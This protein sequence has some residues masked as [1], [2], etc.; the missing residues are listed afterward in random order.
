VYQRVKFAHTA[1]ALNAVPSENFTPLRSLNV[2]AR[3]FLLV[4]HAV[5]SDGTTMLVPFLKVTRLSKI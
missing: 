5:A 3:R 1:A 2:Q 4:V